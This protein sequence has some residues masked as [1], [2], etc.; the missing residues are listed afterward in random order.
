MTDSP[1]DRH[2]LVVV[3]RAGVVVDVVV[4]RGGR[5]TAGRA[6]RGSRPSVGLCCVWWKLAAE[7]S[8]RPPGRPAPTQPALGARRE[9]GTKGNRDGWH[10]R[11]GPASRQPD[12]QA[13]LHQQYNRCSNRIAAT[14]PPP[15]QLHHKV[16]ATPSTC[17]AQ[18][19]SRGGGKTAA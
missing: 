15:Q 6:R 4:S 14:T 13:T 8:N 12:W 16:V 1:V 17:W 2:G 7:P 18:S 9:R 19:S 5:T 3:P 10:G 11:V